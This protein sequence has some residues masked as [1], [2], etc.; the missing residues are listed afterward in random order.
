MCVEDDAKL[1]VEDDA[2]FA[3]FKRFHHVTALQSFRPAERALARRNGL[4]KE[5]ATV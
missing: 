4:E 5:R 2:R 3:K 1:V